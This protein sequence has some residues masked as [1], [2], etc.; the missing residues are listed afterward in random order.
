METCS[1][2]FDV[3]VM[4]SSYMIGLFQDAIIMPN[5]IP[6]T[7]PPTKGINFPKNQAGMDS[8]VTIKIPGN[9]LTKLLFPVI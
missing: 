3:N 1:I 7:G 4:P 5:S 6:N 9:I 8:A 2:V